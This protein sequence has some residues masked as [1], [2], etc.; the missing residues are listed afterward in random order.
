MRGSG[1]LTNLEINNNNNVHNNKIY[2]KND[3]VR[4][5]ILNNTN[6]NKITNILNP[7]FK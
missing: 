1:E 5:I 6:I 4:I 3:N 7:E 2:N